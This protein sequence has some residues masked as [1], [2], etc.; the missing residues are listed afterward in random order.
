M[1]TEPEKRIRGASGGFSGARTGILGGLISPIRGALFFVKHPRLMAYAMIPLI[2]N[3][4]LFTVFFYLSLNRFSGWLERL[5]PSGEAW[6][7]VALTY[8]LTIILAVVL[9]IIIVFTFTVVANILAS[10]FN[11]ALSARTESLR[12]GHKTS[13]PFSLMGILKEAGRTVV[14]EL[15]KLLFYLLV[16]GLLFLLNFIPIMGQILYVGLGAAFTILWIGLSFLDY[17]LARHEYR[18]GGKLRFVRRHFG[19]VLG[20][21]AGVFLGLLIPVF[22][23]VFIPVAVVAG[24]LLYLDLG[25]EA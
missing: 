12:L 17:A 20:Y 9:L 7:W 3:V 4:I 18:F 16:I 21:G 6:Y 5:L 2:I 15:K 13:T 8:L 1:A 10:P 11:D 19:S 24:T 25:D 14:E 22:N 23:L